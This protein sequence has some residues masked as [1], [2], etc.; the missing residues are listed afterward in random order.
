MVESADG[1]I[2]FEGLPNFFTFYINSF[3]N[4]QKK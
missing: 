1:N 3:N 2:V 4:E